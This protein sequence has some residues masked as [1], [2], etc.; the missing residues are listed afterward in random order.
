MRRTSGY[1]G[2]EIPLYRALMGQL[3]GKRPASGR[4]RPLRSGFCVSGNTDRTGFRW[5]E[6]EKGSYR[7]PR[8]SSGCDE[9][10]S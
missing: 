10:V 1:L 5:D 8:L 4:Y 6:K 2:V 7:D 3:Y 9:L